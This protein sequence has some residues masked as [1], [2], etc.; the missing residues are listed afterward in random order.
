MISANVEKRRGIS[1][2][3]GIAVLL[4]AA[5]SFAVT[6]DL[7]A[8][9][10]TTAMPDGAVVN[11]WG[12]AAD[13]GQACD[14]TAGWVP[15]PA[16]SV[17]LPDTLTVN[18]R[19]CL[20]EPASIVIAGQK[21]VL[22]PV[23][24][25][26]DAQGRQ[27]ATS[28]T[29]TAGPSGGTS[30]YTW[31]GLKPG[32]H[33]YESG[34]QPQIQV[35]MGLYGALNVYPAVGLAYPGV[36]FDNE[37]VLLYSEIDK[38]LHEAVA[39]GKY[40]SSCSNPPCTM[41]STIDYKAN[42]FLIDGLPFQ[43]GQAALNAGSSGQTTLLRFLN[44]GL[45]THIPTLHNGGYMKLIAEDGNLYPYPKEQYSVLLPAGKTVDAL[46]NP[47]ADGAFPLF[48]ST[49]QATDGIPGSV[50]LAYL[51]AGA[52][53]SNTPPA[54]NSQIVN[55]NED[56][57]TPIT[58][59]GSDGD[60]NPLTYALVA[61]SGPANGTLSGAAPNLSYTPNANYFGPDSFRFTV[62][63]GQ[64]TS[65]EATVSIT[66]NSV[67]DAPG[68]TAG[69][70]QAVTQ[71]AGAQSVPNWATGI[72]S[73]P[74]NESAQTVSFLVSNNN[75]ALFSA[76]PAVSPAGTLTYTPAAGASGSA[77]VTAQAQDNGGTANGGV[78][79]SAPQIFT[80]T[81]NPEPASDLIFA[82]GFESGNFSAWNAEQ[83]PGGQNDLNVTA[84][85][86]LTG[87][88]GMAATIDDN[89]GMWVMSNTPANETRYRARFRFDPNSVPM[90][91]G[92]AFF[93][94]TARSGNNNT[95]VDVVRIEFA[96]FAGIY[97]VR[98]VSRTDAGGYKNGAWQTV[99][100]SPVV[101][102]FDW[103]AS[104]AAGANNGYLTFWIDGVQKTSSTGIDSD[105][106]RIESARLG[107]LS[108]IDTGTRGTV[109][110]DDFVSRRLNYIGP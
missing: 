99:P 87:G 78:D 7:V 10:F 45:R 53:S 19:N 18:L 47:P 6:V 51:Q 17:T 104:T 16:L 105:T 31:T 92:N 106:L 8:K 62:N 14:E 88:F 66:V 68:F 65:N 80:I 20:D 100:D 41:T 102:E 35:Q 108:G 69:P 89:T 77:T 59:T 21:A 43:E 52:A 101:F 73:G 96:R 25:P 4:L 34:T 42:Y 86:A 48:D 64:S 82:D 63:D 97:H 39:G 94:M 12:F 27:R 107:P 22:A 76:Q 85:A 9:K 44:A 72:S 55:T 71:P 37:V 30:Q 46:W 57:A 103:A 90:T 98:A 93:I 32:T 70:N 40:G 109:Y 38:A 15:G 81:V 60:G 84:A 54:A 1:I 91:N 67:N 49:R 36:P 13:T 26:P 5:P 2:L 95:G 74:A 11:M 56:T 33:L 61:G 79:T 110:F 24:A 23:F 83:D 3:A 50:M 58:L 29:G 75:N 28:F